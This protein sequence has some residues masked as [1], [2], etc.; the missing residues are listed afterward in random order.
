MRREK[1]EEGERKRNGGE[2]MGRRIE[3]EVERLEVRSR[4]P[5]KYTK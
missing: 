3:V 2:V 4:E 1:E 5:Q